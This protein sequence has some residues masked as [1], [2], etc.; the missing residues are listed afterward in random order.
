MLHG[1]PGVGKTALVEAYAN[2]AN[3][4]LVEM[5]ASDFR[6]AARID[7]VLGRSVMQ[8]SLLGRP[9]LFLIDEID[10]LAGRED[11]GGVDAIMKLLK[12]SRYPVVL[13]ANNAYDPKLRGLRYASELVSLRKLALPDL[14]NRLEQVCTIEGVQ[15]D[16]ELL[17][18]IATRNE[19]DLRS[20]LNDLETLAEGKIV[21]SEKDL[22]SL[23]FRERETSVFDA[24]RAL[25]AAS[26]VTGAR[27]ALDVADKD[28]DELF[29]WIESNI[30]EEYEDPAEVAKAFGA[31][32]HADLFKQRIMS[33][34]NWKLLAYSID[35][36]TGGV[37]LAKRKPYRKF[38]K[39]RYP[40]LLMI[41]GRTRFRR[42]ASQAAFRKLGALL[43]C[44]AS[45]VR[46]DFAPYLRVLVRD[47]EYR[48]RFAEAMELDE[49]QVEALL[50][51][52]EDGEGRSLVEVRT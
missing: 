42:S 34:Q 52:A 32:S 28:P 5:N 9:R 47:G 2:E 19:G 17:R 44:S 24:L 27:M 30:A 8:A 31:L 25:F 18:L 36:M 50:G 23:G 33:T 1:P 41:L 38:T 7:E 22:S 6:S 48:R 46:W 45:T 26:S 14:V 16:R 13:V 10:G 21:L 43:H 12:G 49:E 39:Y 20:A 11:S 29:W 15:A 40:D 4:D 3:L 37:A 35:M 51:A